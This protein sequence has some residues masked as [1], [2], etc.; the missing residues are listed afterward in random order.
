MSGEALWG[1]QTVTMSERGLACWAA[2]PTHLLEGHIIWWKKAG[3]KRVRLR[4]KL[5]LGRS[6]V[7]DL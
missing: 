4:F 2:G 6:W 7:F 3:F 1:Q 5:P